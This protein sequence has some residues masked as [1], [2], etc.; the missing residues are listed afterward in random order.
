[1]ANLFN[2]CGCG[3]SST[4]ATKTKD[5]LT[6]NFYMMGE[7]PI[8]AE[9]ETVDVKPTGMVWKGFLYASIIFTVYAFWK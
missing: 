5:L 6:D 1:M 2:D 3:D 4:T 7:N 8:Y 9:L